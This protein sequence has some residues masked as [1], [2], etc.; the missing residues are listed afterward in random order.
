MTQ[1]V[2][3]VFPFGASLGCTPDVLGALDKGWFLTSVKLTQNL[4]HETKS[5]QNILGIW[6]WTKRMLLT[7]ARKNISWL[8]T[9]KVPSNIPQSKE[10]MIEIGRRAQHLKSWY[11]QILK[12]SFK[13][14]L[15]RIHIFSKE[16]TANI[17]TC[18][19]NI[20]TILT[21][22]MYYVLI[23]TCKVHKYIAITYYKIGIQM[24]SVQQITAYV[25]SLG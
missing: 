23:C 6:K 22:D 1:L 2:L 4:Q 10:K 9:Q 13:T 21:Y 11:F 8:N 5:L 19:T 24:K 18:R 25:M 7:C 16:A 15:C 14:F 20:T 3:H 12:T 17:L